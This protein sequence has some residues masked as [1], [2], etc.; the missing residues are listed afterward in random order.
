MTDIDPTADALYNC[1]H[2]LNVVSRKTIKRGPSGTAD[3][4]EELRLPEPD[5][6]AAQAFSILKRTPSVPP[7]LPRVQLF[8]AAAS[9]FGAYARHRPEHE[10]AQFRELVDGF[11]QASVREAAR[12]LLDGSRE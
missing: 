5:A 10:A 6:V 7:G 11:E 4:I 12:Y 8:D 2:A 3:T 1:A 9:F